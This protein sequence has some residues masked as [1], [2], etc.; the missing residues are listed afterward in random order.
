MLENKFSM[1]QIGDT[2]GNDRN[3]K[4]LRY[5][6]GRKEE[7]KKEKNLKRYKL[8]GC[9]QQSITDNNENELINDLY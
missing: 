1:H 8:N 2:Y 4:T 7:L 3:R 5:W 9:G 6:L